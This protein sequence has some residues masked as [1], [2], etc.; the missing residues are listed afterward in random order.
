MEN[1]DIKKAL[2][3]CVKVGGY[4]DAQICNDCPLSEKR[5]AILLPE[6]AL[7]LI[8][9]QEQRIKELTEDLHATR[10][11]LTR[12]QEENE[13]LSNRITC[14]VVLPDEKLEEIKTECLSRVELDIKAVQ[15]DT[16]EEY[17]KRVYRKMEKYT[18]FGREYIQRIMREIA[19]E[20]LEGE[21]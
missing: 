1:N 10:T 16:L 15:A 8:T 3:C 2:E 12:V 4:R 9:S 6:N 20:M 18:V 7:A 21:E 14:Q 5:C 17:R 13:R 11:E 19:K